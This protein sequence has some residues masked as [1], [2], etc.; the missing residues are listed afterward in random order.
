MRLSS[1]PLCSQITS[2]IIKCV[3]KCWIVLLIVGCPPH[4]SGKCSRTALKESKKA[5]SRLSCA[6]CSVSDEEIMQMRFFAR[7]D[8]AVNV[9]RDHGNEVVSF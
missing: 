1:D 2:N 8:R 4:N 9:I 3:F 7:E 6:W 5:S